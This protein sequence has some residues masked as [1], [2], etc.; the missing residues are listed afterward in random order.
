MPSCKD[1]TPHLRSATRC[2]M[3]PSEP[4]P[5]SKHYYLVFLFF[6]QKCH[7]C[8][9]GSVSV[10]YAWHYGGKCGKKSESLT[11][12]QQTAIINWCIN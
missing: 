12:L 11:F 9:N 2:Y 4:N 3:K 5:A 10:V 8:N 1:T 6:L 7:T